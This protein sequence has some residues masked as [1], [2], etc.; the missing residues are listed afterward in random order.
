[1]WLQN[2]TRV[3]A[4]WVNPESANRLKFT[5]P[6]TGQGFSFDIGGLLRGEPFHNDEFFVEVKGYEK[7]EGKQVKAYKQY[8]A[9]CYIAFQK[10][11]ARCN[12]FMY[13][14]WTPFRMP[15]PNGRQRSWAWL[16]SE[17][18]IK[19]ALVDQRDRVFKEGISETDA[20]ELIDQSL[21][22]E[23]AERLWVL[24]LTKKQEELVITPKHRQMVYGD[25]SVD[26]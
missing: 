3:S 18:C 22:T 1:M 16:Q 17:D 4:I 6:G 11:P 20:K 23:I 8:L 24:V 10:E 25:W 13:I 26:S 12:H 21:V 2:T 9:Q 15:A 5:W 19:S 7:N 14:T